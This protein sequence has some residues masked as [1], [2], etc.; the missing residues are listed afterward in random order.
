[1]RVCIQLQTAV[2]NNA[3][4][5]QPSE[6][7]TKEASHKQKP[8]LQSSQE[9]SGEEIGRLTIVMP[10]L[11]Y[12]KRVLKFQKAFRVGLAPRYVFGGLDSTL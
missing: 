12:V 7:L 10:H 6:E 4:N 2:I 3:F 8:I 9:E 1:M 11:I 5:P